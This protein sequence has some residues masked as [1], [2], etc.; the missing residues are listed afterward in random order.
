[1]LIEYMLILTFFWALYLYFLIPPSEREYH[2]V[3]HLKHKGMD[4]KKI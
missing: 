2:Y 4:A 1:M 3:L